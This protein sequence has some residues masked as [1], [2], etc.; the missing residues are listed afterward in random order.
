MHPNDP[1]P[2]GV[3]PCRRCLSV[4]GIHAWWMV[5]CQICGNKRCPHA[6]DCQ[7][8]CTNSNKVGQRGSDWENVKPL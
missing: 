6:N 4:E 5:V 2:P 1:T 8:H 7:N 3:C